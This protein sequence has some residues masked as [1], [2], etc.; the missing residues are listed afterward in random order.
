MGD[1]DRE[2]WGKNNSHS[3][4]RNNILKF[5]QRFISKTH[6]V[7]YFQHHVA[8]V[9]VYYGALHFPS[10]PSHSHYQHHPFTQTSFMSV[11]YNI[12]LC[13]EIDKQLSL[14]CNPLQVLILSK[15]NISSP[16]III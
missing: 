15:N 12:C 9:V 10:S 4:Q 7:S 6:L 8:R 5:K 3:S 11:L 14:K 2:K 16:F 13:S 1:K